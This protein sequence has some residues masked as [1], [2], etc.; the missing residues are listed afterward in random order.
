MPNILPGLDNS[1]ENCFEKFK[2]FKNQE[3]TKE[4]KE[5]VHDQNGNVTTYIYYRSYV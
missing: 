3:G 4:Y 1:W 5:M 2:K